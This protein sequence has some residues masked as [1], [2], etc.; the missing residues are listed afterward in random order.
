MI[1]GDRKGYRQTV[2]D[3]LRVD[4]AR[5]AARSDEKNTR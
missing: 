4:G 3:L 1:S 5:R 2:H